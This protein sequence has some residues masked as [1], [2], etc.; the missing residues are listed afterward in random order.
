MELQVP[1][2][3][4]APCLRGAPGACNGITLGSGMM[5]ETGPFLRSGRGRSRG[6]VR[7]RKASSDTERE[8]T[9]AQLDRFLSFSSCLGT[10]AEKPDQPALMVDACA[11][12]H[13]DHYYWQQAVAEIRGETNYSQLSLA[14]W[15][16]IRFKSS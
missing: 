8:T 5:K 11:A 2:G 12:Q 4:A 7:A 16:D 1:G 9:L 13:S 3:S 10:L 14:V 15:H 6:R